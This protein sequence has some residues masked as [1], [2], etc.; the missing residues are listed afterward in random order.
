M[1][2]FLKL[3]KNEFDIPLELP[4]EEELL[5]E[6]GKMDEKKMTSAFKNIVE[7][8]L[9]ADEKVW[10][11]VLDNRDMVVEKSKGRGILFVFLVKEKNWNWTMM[12]P[13]MKEKNGWESKRRRKKRRKKKSKMK[14]MTMMKTHPRSYSIFFLQWKNRPVQVIFRLL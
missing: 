7:G 13:M 14:T 3:A 2:P 6:D 5:G 11:N 4:K 12:T 1:N 9:N 10:Q 8:V